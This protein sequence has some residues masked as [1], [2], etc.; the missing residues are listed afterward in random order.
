MRKHMDGISRAA[1]AVMLAFSL[2]M[3]ACVFARAS[4]D[5]QLEDTARSL[6]T[7]RGRERKQQHEY[8][9]VTAELPLVRAELEE[10]QPRA[11]AAAEEVRTL[12]EERKR[13]RAEK[14]E[15]EQAAESPES[16]PEQDGGTRP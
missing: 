2:F 3:A 7:S 13:L 14:K 8:D 4:L 12:K 1:A 15:L 9:E 5:F 16:G 6:E 10:L 11:D